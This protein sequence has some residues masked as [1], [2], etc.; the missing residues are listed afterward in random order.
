MPSALSDEAKASDQIDSRDS[1]PQVLF[2]IRIMAWWT[3]FEASLKFRWLN[4]FT[5]DAF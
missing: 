1:R 5:S 4:A 3:A 2:L